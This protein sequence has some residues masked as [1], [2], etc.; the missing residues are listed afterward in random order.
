MGC[1]PSKDGGGGG[2]VVDP[3][4]TSAADKVCTT[5]DGTAGRAAEM[6][7]IPLNDD[8]K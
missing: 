7:L 4:A 8:G 2:G 6:L 5:S 1:N 3:S